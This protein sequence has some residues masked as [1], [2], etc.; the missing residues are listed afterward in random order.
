MVAQVDRH[1]ISSDPKKGKVSGGIE[2]GE[3]QIILS[4]AEP[5]GT[6]GRMKRCC[7]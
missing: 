2:D 6:A 1:R 7:K 5:H 4:L 3:E